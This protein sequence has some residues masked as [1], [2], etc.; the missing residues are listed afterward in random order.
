M[1]KNHNADIIL[2]ND[3]NTDLKMYI[4]HF[5]SVN[6]EIR[7]AVMGTENHDENHITYFQNPI[8]K[9]FIILTTK[10]D[11]RKNICDNMFKLTGLSHWI[12]KNQNNNAIAF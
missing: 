6:P 2:L 7:V 3:R 8:T 4:H 1:L 5:E 9:Q 12:W 10:F 11:E